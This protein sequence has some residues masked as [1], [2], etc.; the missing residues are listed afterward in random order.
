VLHVAPNGT[1]L[2]SEASRYDERDRRTARIK[3]DGTTDLF[4]YDPAGQVVAAAYAQAFDSSKPLPVLASPQGVGGM[5][6]GASNP[7]PGS[8]VQP[9]ASSIQA[10]QTFAYDPMGNR[11]QFQDLDGTQIHYQTNEA[12]QYQQLSVSS[13]N[14][15]VEPKYDKNGNLLMD[16]KNTYTWDADIHL[17]AVETK[18]SIKDHASSI[19]KFRYDPLHRRVARLEPDGTLT[20]FVHDGWNV[21]EERVTNQKS[22]IV[23]HKCL[24]WSEDLSGTMQGAG[25]IAG[26]IKTRQV[27]PSSIFGAERLVLL[28]QQ[29]QRHP[30][31]QRRVLS[32][33]PLQLRRLRQNPN[34][35]RLRRRNQPLPL[36]HQAD[37]DR[38]RA[39]LLRLPVLLAGVGKVDDKR[40]DWRK[41]RNKPDGIS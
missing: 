26:L 4:A 30:A 21:I 14:S 18:S 10:E 35:H 17:L 32:H 38:Q 6:Q 36:Q 40:P 34:R 41:R 33:R 19:T 23:N 8:S 3:G 7:N 15:V 28:R 24:V 11:K 29:R 39:V 1:I 9:Q 2:S 5:E 20:H 27:S 16:T 12:N 22:K 31:H 25:G 37:G 13:V